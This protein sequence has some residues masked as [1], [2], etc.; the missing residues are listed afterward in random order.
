MFFI[1]FMIPARKSQ[2]YTLKKSI[3]SQKSLSLK[4]SFAKAVI[5]IHQAKIGSEVI[6]E[7]AALLKLPT[8]KE[9]KL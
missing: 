5:A 6:L 1:T 8:T 2:R 4:V 9:R 7:K 3:P